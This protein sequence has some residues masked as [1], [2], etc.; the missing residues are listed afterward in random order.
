MRGVDFAGSREVVRE[1]VPKEPKKLPNELSSA[2]ICARRDSPSS[3]AGPVVWAG[4]ELNRDLFISDGGLKSKEEEAGVVLK[5]EFEGE[6]GG[7]GL[8]VEEAGG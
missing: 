7:R 4:G 6:L 3:S 5:D 2:V 8:E 1:L